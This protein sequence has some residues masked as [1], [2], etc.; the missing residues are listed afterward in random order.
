MND[1]EQ[2]K[3]L[4]KTFLEGFTEELYSDLVVW[5]EQLE[6]NGRTPRGQAKNKERLKF[7]KHQVDCYEQFKGISTMPIDNIAATFSHLDGD[8]IDSI[9]NAFTK[10]AKQIEIK[11]G[12]LTVRNESSLSEKSFKET[13]KLLSAYLRSFKGFHSKALEGEVTIVL[14]KA[15]DLNSKAKYDS[16]KDEILVRSTLTFPNHELPWA[17]GHELGHRYERLYGLPE[18]FW[19][20]AFRTTR[21]S[22]TESLSGSSEAFAEIFVLSLNPSKY[23]QY[24]DTLMQ[25]GKLVRG[26]SNEASLSL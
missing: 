10:G 19:E 8:E 22:Y 6:L 7:I 1:N 20:N 14:K 12:P 23:P 18:G 26:H 25:F 21:Y 5:L 15:S 3:K 9:V 17:V 2:L 13:A 11:H 16:E 24:K 4:G